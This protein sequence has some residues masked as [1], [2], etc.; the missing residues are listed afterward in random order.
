MRTFV[1]QAADRGASLIVFPEYSSYFNRRIGSDF[2][3][4]AQPLDGEFVTTLRQLAKSH[5]LAIIAGLVEKVDGKRRF[6]NTAVAIDHEGALAA[7]YRKVHLFD[8]F[9][10]RESDWVEPG[11]PEQ[12]TVF[13][14]AGIAIGIETCY[15]LRF[16]E[17][18]RRLIDAGAEMVVIPAQWVPGPLKESHWST[19]LAARAIENT[20]YIVAADHS[21]PN[22][23]GRSQIVDPM[24]VIVASAGAE[25][26]LVSGEVSLERVAEV[27][28]TNPSIELRRY[29]VEANGAAFSA[30]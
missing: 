9:G 7:L 19:L 25:D 20:I 17:V 18:S 6:A 11:D 28:A 14:V 5:D 22:G 10:A 15:D 26:T 12:A 21:T 2:V 8:A 27:R 3:D 1:R 23:V 13:E 29:A 30:S 4:H 16:P 24:G